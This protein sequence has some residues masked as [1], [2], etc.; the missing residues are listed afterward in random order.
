MKY[1]IEYDA[2]LVKIMQKISRPDLL[3]IKKEIDSKLRS[4]PKVFGKPLRSNLKNL[5][6]LRI[7]SYR[8][9]YTV[10]NEKCMVFVVALG[11]RSDIYD[12]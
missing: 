5:W 1:S 4:Y 8:V 6:S 7:G 12:L 11:K 10:E 9:I 3:R 2:S